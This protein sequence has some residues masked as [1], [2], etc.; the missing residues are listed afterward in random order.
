MYVVYDDECYVKPLQ[1]EFPDA[2]LIHVN[3]QLS[4]D[5]EEYIV[6]LRKPDPEWMDTVRAKSTIMGYYYGSKAQL[7][8]QILFMCD[9]IYTQSNAQKE[10]ILTLSPHKEVLVLKKR[11]IPVMTLARD[12]APYIGEYTECIH[13]CTDFDLNVFILE[14]DS[15][16]GTADLFKKADPCFNVIDLKLGL[17]RLPGGRTHHRTQ[18]L[19]LLRNRLLELTDISCG[20]YTMILDTQVRWTP[21]ILQSHVDLLDQNPD[22]AMVTSW[23]RVRRSEPCDFHFDTYATIINGR[24][25]DYNVNLWPCEHAGTKHDHQC[26]RNRG[27][28]PIHDEKK[29]IDVDSACGGLFLIRSSVLKKCRWNVSHPMGCEHWDFCREVKK[30]GRIVINPLPGAVSWEG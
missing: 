28:P 13:A 2:K 19:A 6:A 9:T 23:G 7:T 21:Q 22:V 14:N 3:T 20:E 12:N 1:V 24:P 11:T 8:S 27:A 18:K 30:Y 4:G 17:P 16:D 26:H 25:C 15:T 29:V 5:K 10:A